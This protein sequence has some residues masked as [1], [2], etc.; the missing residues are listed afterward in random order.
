M[1]FYNNPSFEEWKWT[2]KTLTYNS[3]S[4]SHSR[5]IGNLNLSASISRLEDM[6]YR[7]NDEQLRYSAFLKANYHFSEST[8]LSF[9]GNR[10]YKETKNIY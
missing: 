9:Y 1:V 7:K 4:F 2:D 3:Q 10:L 5:S 8:S 6:S